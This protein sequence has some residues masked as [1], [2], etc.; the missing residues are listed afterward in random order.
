MSCIVLYIK[1]SYN[2]YR[3]VHNEQCTVPDQT[4]RIKHVHVLYCT[5]TKVSVQYKPYCTQAWSLKT[6][7]PA[8]YSNILFIVRCYPPG[9]VL[10]NRQSRRYGQFLE[11]ETRLYAQLV[12]ELEPAPIRVPTAGSNA[13]AGS[14]TRTYR[15]LVLQYP[16]VNNYCHLEAVIIFC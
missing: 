12:A 8:I 2:I 7:K 3:T 1:E 10:W 11:T 5:Y 15:I 14:C 9:A 6:A 16:T 13:R 4:G